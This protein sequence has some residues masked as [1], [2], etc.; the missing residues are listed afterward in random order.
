M[1]FKFR[2]RK[3]VSSPNIFCLGTFQQMAFAFPIRQFF[4]GLKYPNYEA[5][6]GKHVCAAR[7]TITAIK[8][9][10]GEQSPLT[11]GCLHVVTGMG[12]HGLGFARLKLE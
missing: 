1:E 10:I 5:I 12:M 11:K 2:E 3:S 9:E 6:A 4:W 7:V 8:N